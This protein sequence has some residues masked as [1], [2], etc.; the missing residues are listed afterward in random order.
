MNSSLERDYERLHR[1][2]HQRSY[3]HFYSLGNNVFS[4]GYHCPDGSYQCGIS[5]WDG[6]RFEIHSDAYYWERKNSSDKT[7]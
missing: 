5:R 3:D 7:C 6:E 4:Y 2:N 1:G